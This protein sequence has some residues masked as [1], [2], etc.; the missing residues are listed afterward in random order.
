MADAGASG[1]Q[2]NVLGSPLA[3]CSQMPRTGFLRTGCCDSHP[4][5]VG[6]H[7]VC[8]VM[9]KEFLL[10][11]KE[12]G[13]DLSTPMPEHGFAGLKP[14]DRWCLCA[15]R[16]RQ[17]LAAGH[18]PQVVLAATHEDALAI[19]SLDDLMAHAADVN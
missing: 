10:F 5:D 18:A 8:T 17:A 12:A 19:V 11:S 3:D 16:W 4:Q 6:R 1:G 7:L 2:R 15:A 9:T 14:G 13:N